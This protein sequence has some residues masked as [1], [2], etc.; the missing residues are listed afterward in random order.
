MQAA[1]LL[2]KKYCEYAEAEKEAAGFP[3]DIKNWLRYELGL[4]PR[5]E[6]TKLICEAAKTKKGQERD[7]AG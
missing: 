6:A 5:S 7:G 2:V 1:K 4:S 3:M